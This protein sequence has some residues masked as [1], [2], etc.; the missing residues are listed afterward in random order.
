[1]EIW[2]KLGCVREN[3]RKLGVVTDIQRK[4]G[5]VT[6]VTQRTLVF[7]YRRTQKSVYEIKFMVPNKQI[8]L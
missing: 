6:D 5:G 8:L 2:R 7:H 1:M 3:R 4:L